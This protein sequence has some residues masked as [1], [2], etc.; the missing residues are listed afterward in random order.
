M[1]TL[2]MKF[3]GAS[4]ATPSHIL[5]AA[6]LIVG[7]ESQYDQVVVVV[8]AMGS[9][10]NE[11]M[12]LAS[13]V[14]REPSRREHDML[15]SVGERISMSLLAM[16]LRDRGQEAISLTGSQSGIVTSEDHS[17]ALII[18]VRAKRVVEEL[19]K[20]RVVIV[21]GFQGVSIK[22]EITTLGRGGSDT[23]AVALG[24][25]LEAE[26]VEF[27]KEVFGVYSADPKS[28]PEATLHPHL[29]FEEAEKLCQGERF[30]LHP[31]AISLAS[32]NGLPLHVLTFREGAKVFPGT[33]ISDGVVGKRGEPCYEI[34]PNSTVKCAATR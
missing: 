4:L 28:N 9:M 1:K 18:D 2:V 3:G 27:Y 20:G 13:E 6:D 16:A 32:K 11:L 30:I 26:K 23:T 21:A 34:I 12:K 7:R 29:T 14:S 17:K 8:S 10:T 33:H 15:V 24:V 31:R 22:K 5:R 19:E 25:A